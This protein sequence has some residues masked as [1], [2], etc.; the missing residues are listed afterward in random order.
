MQSIKQWFSM[1]SSRE[2]IMVSIAA[3]CVFSFAI[4]IF[5]IQP[6]LDKNKQLHSQLQHR[7]SELS[8]MQNNGQTIK[9]LKAA[10]AGKAAPKAPRNPSRLI[11]QTLKRYQ[12]KSGLQRM[13]GRERV[14]IHLKDVAADKVMQWLGMLEYHHHLYIK[15]FEITPK[16]APGFIDITLTLGN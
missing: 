3:I 16:K 1:L 9:Q 13:Q 14:N 12:L 15:Q 11:E 2:Q 5:V 10:G 6:I 4:W 8:W 7:T